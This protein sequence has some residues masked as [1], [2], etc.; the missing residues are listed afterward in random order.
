[1]LMTS[2]DVTNKRPVTNIKTSNRISKSHQSGRDIAKRS[3][4]TAAFLPNVQIDQSQ[5][6]FN[7]NTVSPSIANF[8]R[9]QA[10]RIRRS[11][12][13][14]VIN[15]GKDLMSV[16]RYLP[17][18][19]FIM[20]VEGEIG[21]SARTAQI[22][23]QVAQWAESNSVAVAHL[24]LSTL[25]AISAP[26]TPNEFAKEILK[27]IE[28]GENISA[29]DIRKEL[30]ALRENRANTSNAATDVEITEVKD[31]RE[32]DDQNHRSAAEAHLGKMPLPLTGEIQEN[33]ATGSASVLA[34]V[35]GIL[36]DGLSKADFVRVCKIM[37]SNFV[38]NDPEIL[39][40]ITNVFTKA[41]G[42]ISPPA[43]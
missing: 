26:S 11:V 39:K 37:T 43:E 22:Y 19:L 24:P 34:E 12:A 31:R 27:R 33:V 13:S 7:Y 8:L 10:D 35:V 42:K 25:Y 9:S 6:V 23:M 5:E 2:I 38:I 1:M 40:N 21:I 41:L 29:K 32:K 28:D 4:Q 3:K 18:G 20:W 16:K 15:I 14:S 30:K 36:A 17:H